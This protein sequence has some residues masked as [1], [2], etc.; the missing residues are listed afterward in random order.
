VNARLTA[1]SAHAAEPRIVHDD[2]AFRR[3]ID[4]WISVPPGSAG[5]KR[6]TRSDLRFERFQAVRPRV[7][8]V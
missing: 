6:L 1:P 3:R 8:G 7:V 2:V 4:T 5:V